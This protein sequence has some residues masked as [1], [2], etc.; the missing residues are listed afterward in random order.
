MSLRSPLGKVLG[1]GTA[2]DGTDHWW[3]QRMSA[4]ALALLGT[5]FVASLL[6]LPGLEQAVVV[7]FIRAP[8]NGILMALLC[9]TLAYHSYLGVQVVLEDYVHAPGLKV[10][11]LVAS[12]FAHIFVA[13]A[14]I[15]A[16]L[17]IG[18]GA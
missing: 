8:L 12:R 1:L 13:V 18:L 16:V 4:V 14:S 17:K 15:Y 6:R 7:D 9:A 2:K 5:W 11:S 3:A 10:V